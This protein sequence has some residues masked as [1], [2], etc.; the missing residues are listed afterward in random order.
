PV[1][2]LPS[3]ALSPPRD[4]SGHFSMSTRNL[5]VGVSRTGE[6][7][8]VKLASYWRGPQCRGG[9]LRDGELTDLETALRAAG[10]AGPVTGLRDFLE[11]PDWRD[12]V[13]RLGTMPGLTWTPLPG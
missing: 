7:R 3:T 5:M 10:H 13:G 4:L 12:W 8:P 6:D 9:L 2:S 11:L 1:R